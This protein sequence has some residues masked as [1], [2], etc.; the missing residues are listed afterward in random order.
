MD[1]ELIKKELYKKTKEIMPEMIKLNKWLYENPETP[2][3]EYQAIKEITTNLKENG[4]EVNYNIAG[5]DTAFTAKKIIGTGGPKIGFLAEYDALPE[6]GH[7]CGHNLIAASCVGA[8]IALAKT[9]TVPAEIVVYGTPD[10]EFDGGK[11]IMA[12]KGVF[13][14]LDIALQIHPSAD[15]TIVDV[16]SAPHQTMVIGYKGCAAHTAVNPSAG[17]NA[18]NAVHVAFSG[19]HALQQYLKPGTRIPATI[20]HGGGAPNAV[21]QFAQ[22]RIHITTQDHDYL[23]EVVKKVENCAKAGSLATGAED[24]IWK[25]PIYKEILPNPI[26]ND[27]IS[28]QLEDL[29]YILDKAPEN[30]GATDVGN[31]SWS[32]PTAMPIVSLGLN[33]VPLHSKEFAAAT[34]EKEGEI[35][36]ENSINAMAVVAAKVIYSSNLIEKIRSTFNS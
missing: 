32:C 1:F 13:K 25:S 8:A 2:K 3:N 18:L 12:E 35:F 16:R 26:L 34:V 27:L 14:D 21:P 22:F 30:L 17:I 20:T 4:F 29:G 15:N 5:L 28:Q 9:L 36:L 31:V 11:I 24:D 33:N 10:E 19:L 23:E 7:G 6:V